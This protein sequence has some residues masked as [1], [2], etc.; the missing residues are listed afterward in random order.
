MER[1]SGARGRSGDAR[2]KDNEIRENRFDGFCESWL[3]LW[4]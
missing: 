1:S 4:P 3:H 2:N